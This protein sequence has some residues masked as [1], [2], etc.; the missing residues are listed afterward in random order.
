MAPK[1]RGMSAGPRHGRRYHNP[2]RSYDFPENPRP[3]QPIFNNI[4]VAG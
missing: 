2:Y 4:H 3:C 1:N